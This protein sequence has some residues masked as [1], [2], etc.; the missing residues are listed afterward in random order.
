M[1]HTLRLGGGVGMVLVTNPVLRHLSSSSTGM[2]SLPVSIPK[3]NKLKADCKQCPFLHSLL[4]S[5]LPGW[6][7]HRALTNGPVGHVF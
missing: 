4:D 6:F 2:R 1:C 5:L 7:M 3:D